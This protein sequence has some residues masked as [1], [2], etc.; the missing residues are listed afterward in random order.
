MKQSVQPVSVAELKKMKSR[1][2]D[3][4]ILDT[5]NTVE[6]SDGF[7]PGSI[8]IGSDGNFVEWALDLLPLTVRIV[9]IAEKDKEEENI[10]RLMGAGFANIE[11]FLEGGFAAWEK[12][13]GEIDMIINVDAAE[14]AMDIPFDENLIVLDVR[15]PVEYAEGHVENAINVPLSDLSDPGN[16]V[17]FEDRNNLYIHCAGGYRSVIAASILKQQGYHNIRNISGGWEYIKHTKGINIV[18]ET[19]ALN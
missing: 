14:L 16:L 12:A 18:K 11:G 7:V 5:R 9:L 8:F 15:R 10:K 17:Q 3:F 6:F 19:S 2:E 1:D 13:G 4:V